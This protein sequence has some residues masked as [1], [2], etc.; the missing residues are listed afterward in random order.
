MGRILEESLNEIY[1]FDTETLRF[2][3]VNR[4]ARENLGYSMRELENLTP[5]DLEPEYTPEAF[6][7]LIRP[8]RKGTRSRVSYTSV[9]RRKDDSLYDVEVHLQTCEYESRSA[10][11]AIV[12]DITERRETIEA[13]RAEH[14]FVQS[15]VETAQAVVLVLDPQGRIMQFNPFM[16][17]LSGYRLDEVLGKNWFTAFLPEDAQTPMRRVFASS[18]KGTPARGDV[19]PILTKDGS[20][21]EIAWWDETLKDADENVVGVLAIGHDVT[22][23]REA[24]RRVVQSERLAAI[25]EMAAGLAH[26]SR[27]ALQ[28][29][30]ACLEMLEV[31]L[32]DRPEELDLVRRIQTAQDHLHRLYE[33]ARE[34]A[35]P[36]KLDCQPCDLAHV[37]RD[38]WAHLQLARAGRDIE[39]REEIQDTDLRCIVDPFAMGQVFRNIMENAIAACPEPGVVVIRC[40]VLMDGDCSLLRVSVCD[41]GPGLSKEQKT[42]LF[43]PFFTT[44]TKGTG[45]GMAIAWRIIN[46]HGG[47]IDVGDGPGAEIVLTV[48][49]KP[50]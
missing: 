8:L 1:I 9:H 27:N 19:Y 24:Q 50:E 13:L 21:R 5:P 38:T 48:P 37:W 2:I 45:L 11:A 46:A 10:F 49:R 39:L 35:A 26:E 16:E 12:L 23:L 36:I 29:S 40:S 47:R 43:D 7:E 28:R 30:Q 44:K 33:E 17:K 18:L 6:V 14:Q 20:V 15:L 3:Q 34:Y 32:E 41:N 22:E 42:K 25:G 31:E 4:G